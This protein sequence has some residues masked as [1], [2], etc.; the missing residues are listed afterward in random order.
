MTIPESK[1]IPVTHWNQHYE[2]PTI[3]GLRYLI[4][5]EHQ[6]GFSKCVKRVGRRVLIDSELF[7]AWVEEQNSSQKGGQ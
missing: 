3:A 2:W 4:F 7:R 6:N 1:L 5:N